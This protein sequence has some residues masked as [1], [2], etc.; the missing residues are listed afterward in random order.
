[1]VLTILR[2]DIYRALRSPSLLVALVTVV[3]L[4]GYSAFSLFAS[5]SGVV[6][7]SLI[8][9]SPDSGPAISEG[10]PSITESVGSLGLSGGFLP[11]VSSLVVTLFLAQGIRSGYCGGLI[12]A[13]ASRTTL[14]LEALVVSLASSSVL[15]A[16]CFVPYLAGYALMGMWQ[17][18]EFDFGA[19]SVWF[20]LANLHVFL[21]S[22]LVGCV[23]IVT[24]SRVAGVTVALTVS[25][26]ILEMLLV[27]ALRSAGGFELVSSALIPLL[28]D[29]IAEAM[30]QPPAALFYQYVGSATLQIVAMVTY[31]L[32]TMVVGVISSALCRRVSIL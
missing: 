31:S 17:L 13:G 28:P 24:R 12:S 2:A 29:S 5:A 18:S 10:V 4:S 32:L 25:T 30:C 19:L 1:M 6:T 3:V 16:A 15:L 9:L 27:A 7:P 11:V 20:A 22:F 21:Y 14:I 23:T 26:G 8:L